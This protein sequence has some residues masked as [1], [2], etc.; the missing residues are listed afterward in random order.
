MTPYLY[1]V[2]TAFAVTSAY[3]GTPQY[4]VRFLQAFID[5]SC[6]ELAVNL[7]LVIFARKIFH[8]ILRLS[9]NCVSLA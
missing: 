9:M 2:D 5:I 1:I 8:G 3:L 4:V 6:R 7:N